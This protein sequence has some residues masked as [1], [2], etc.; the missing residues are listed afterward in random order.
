M[1]V[2]F[3]RILCQ[4]IKDVNSFSFTQLCFFYMS[5]LSTNRQPSTN[6]P[7]TSP[8]RYRRTIQTR[9]ACACH[10]RRSWR[11]HCSDHERAYQMGHPPQRLASL[12]ITVPYLRKGTTYISWR[13]MVESRCLVRMTPIVYQPTWSYF[14]NCISTHNHFLV[15]AD[16]DT[17]PLDDLNQLQSGQD[18]H[19]NK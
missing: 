9:D 11:K 5:P 8:W 4:E 2:N 13:K 1:N 17:L 3:P 10:H 14:P 7:L 12:S 6:I 18:Y 19:R 15:L 16:L